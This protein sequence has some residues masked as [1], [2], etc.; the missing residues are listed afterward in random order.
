MNP[1]TLIT[2]IWLGVLFAATALMVPWLLY[3]WALAGLAVY[4]FNPNALERLSKSKGEGVVQ[5]TKL[6]MLWSAVPPLILCIGWAIT[7]IIGLSRRRTP[8]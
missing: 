8:K 6:L 3:L 5:T 1:S 2:R 4:D 7:I